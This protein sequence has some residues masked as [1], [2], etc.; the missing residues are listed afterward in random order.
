V[1]KETLP[2]KNYDTYHPTNY[3]AGKSTKHSNYIFKS[4]HYQIIGL[5]V[6]QLQ[7]ALYKQTLITL[8]NK[9]TSGCWRRELSIWLYRK[10]RVQKPTDICPLLYAKQDEHNTSTKAKQIHTV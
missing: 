1:V 4:E 5:F 8:F 10:T 6:C 9:Y 3:C 7:D 2:P